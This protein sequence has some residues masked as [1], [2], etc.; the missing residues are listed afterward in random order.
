MDTVQKV[1]GDYKKLNRGK[2][3]VKTINNIDDNILRD[4]FCSWTILISASQNGYT[5]I[6]KRCIH[7]G[8]DPNKPDPIGDPPLYFVLRYLHFNDHSCFSS[9]EILLKAGADPN[10]KIKRVI[11]DNCIHIPVLFY[12]HT[13]TEITKFLLEHGALT[14]E[15]YKYKEFIE[16]E[17]RDYFIKVLAKRRWVTIKCVVLTLGI[18]KRAVIKANHPDRLLEQGVF[19]I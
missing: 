9:A 7:F 14:N 2:K 13:G 15:F 1:F 16:P 11:N 5:D 10:I 17:S 8:A 12:L 18:H 3:Y 4:D 19:E 6:L